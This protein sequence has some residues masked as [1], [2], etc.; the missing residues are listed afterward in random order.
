MTDTDGM[1]LELRPRRSPFADGHSKASLATPSC[2]CCCCCVHAIG[3]TS[4]IIGGDIAARAREAGRSKNDSRWLGLAGFLTLPLLIFLTIVLAE[5]A[6]VGS[7]TAILAVAVLGFVLL[8]SGLR[9]IA[10]KGEST[11]SAGGIGSSIAILIFLVVTSIVDAIA[12]L[13]VI[14]S[15]TGDRAAWALLATVPIAVWAGWKFATGIHGSPQA[16]EDSSNMPPPSG[17]LAD[18]PLDHDET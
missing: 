3:A 13:G 7:G 10:S 15:N 6:I 12:I 5:V 18:T 16:S 9:G 2:C 8:H 4:G 14:D 1:E 11:F 17:K